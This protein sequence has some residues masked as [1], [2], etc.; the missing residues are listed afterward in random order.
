GTGVAGDCV[1]WL[2]TST[3]GD[4]GAGCGGSGSP[5]GT[6]GQVQ[7]NNTGTFGGFTLGG[8]ATLNTGTGALTFATVNA[9]VGSFGSATNCT[10][11]TVNAKGLITAAS[12]ATCTPAIGSVTGLGTGVGAALAIAT[13][14]AGSFVVNG[15]ALGTPSSGTLTNATGLPISTGVS[16]LATGVA[17]FLATPSSANLLAALTTKTGTGNAVFGS[18]PTIDS[19]NA[20]TA[21]TLAFLTGGGTQC[22]Q[23]S[24]T[25]VVSGT[26]AA[27]GSGGS[28]TITAGT[29]P[30]SGI[31]ANHAISS[32]GTTVTDGGTIVNSMAAG[33]GTSNGGTST[34]AVTLSS[35][36]TTRVNSTT[37]DTIV[38][39]DC[40][41]LVQENNAGSIA[42][43]IA[44]A[45]TTGFANGAYFPVCNIG[46]GT[47]TITPTTST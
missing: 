21:L 38:N 26:G 1:K 36:M 35:A 30:T 32:N 8:D 43:A 19:L 3:I 20:T 40:G 4:F 25:G 9:N 46:A 17:T 31:T 23:V 12:Q 39:T 24:N 44:Q 33:C 29:T 22:V 28:T 10:S 16:G 27:C 47:A 2:T 5:G 7:F 45:G 6:A 15:G 11:V 41:N 42:V 13:G 37:S 14:S 34:G 18:A